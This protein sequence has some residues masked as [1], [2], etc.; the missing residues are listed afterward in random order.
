MNFDGAQGEW[1][2][3]WNHRWTPPTGNLAGQ[4]WGRTLEL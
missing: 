3:S 1:L 2:A 4:W